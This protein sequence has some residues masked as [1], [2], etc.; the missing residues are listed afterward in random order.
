MPAARPVVLAFPAAGSLGRRCYLI[1]ANADF[2]EVAI[3]R[4]RKDVPQMADTADSRLSQLCLLSIS[5]SAPSGICQPV[6]S[7][8][9]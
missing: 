9:P 2:D 3:P 6:H 7:V 1:V 5:P 8:C 4:S